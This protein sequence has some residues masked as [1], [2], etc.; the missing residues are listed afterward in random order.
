MEGDELERNR[1]ELQNWIREKVEKR[2]LITPYLLE[3]CNMLQSLL[4][5]REKRA[6]KLLKLWESVAACEATLKKQYSLLGLEY[7]DT[8]S[9]D[10]DVGTGCEHVPHL[11][12]DPVQSET[13]G[14]LSPATRGH[15]LNG[16]HDKKLFPYIR[17]SV[18][19]LTRLP[20]WKIATLLQSTSQEDDSD[21]EILSNIDSDDQWEPEISSSDSDCSVLFNNKRRKKEQKSN[22]KLGKSHETQPVASKADD[23]DS[24]AETKAPQASNQSIAE[25]GALKTESPPAKTEVTKVPSVCSLSAS[26]QTTDKATDKTTK[27]LPCVPEKELSVDT[28]VVARRRQLKWQQGKIKEILTKKD[29]RLKYKV[30]FEEMGKMLVSGYHIALDHIPEVEQLFVGARVVVK[31][32]ADRPYFCPGVIAEVP[33]RKN[34]YRFLAFYDDHTAVYVGLS[35]LH[36]VYQPL[37]E[38]LDDIV[39]KVHRAFM[40]DYLESWPHPPQAYY[41]RGQVIKAEFNGVQQEC[42]VRQVDCSLIEV[43]FKGDQHTE[44]IYRGSM[45]LEQVTNMRAQMKF[46][47]EKRKGRKGRQFASVSNNS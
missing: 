34:S 31:C 17:N 32:K 1:D 26:C 43:V 18:V 15:T 6:A 42:E 33:C 14:C 3:K 8:D 19:S 20:E 25:Y 38:P 22:E 47:K 23:D 16:N 37:T 9:E 28:T 35:L 46:D 39:D 21:N 5:R 10:D 45:R 41:K 13:R 11:S 30:V 44:W 2:E 40:K 29:G 24:I 36:K 7:R 4:E 12:N 27:N